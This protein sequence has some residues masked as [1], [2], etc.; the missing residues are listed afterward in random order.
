MSSA[1]ARKPIFELLSLAL[2]TVAQ[3]ASYTLMQFIDRWMLSRLGGDAPTAAANAGMLSFS[4]VA[5]GMGIIMLVNTLV[6]QSFGRQ[7][8]ARCGQYL[9]QGIWL[10]LVLGLIMLPLRFIAPGLFAIFHHPAQQ[11]AMEISYYQIVLLC[12]SIKLSSFALSQFMLGVDRPNPVLFSAVFGVA[13]NA[14][15]AWCVVLGHWGFSKHGIIGAAW[16]QNLGVACELLALVAFALQPSIRK[17]Y[18]VLSPALH[19]DQLFTLVK[20]GLPSGLQFFSDVLAWSIFCNGV[21][22]ILGAPAMRANTFML[23]YMVVSFMPAFGLSAA[24]TALVGRYIGSGQPE[25]SAR[26]GSLGFLGH[27]SLYVFLRRDLHPG[28]RAADAILYE[29]S[30][31]DPHRRN[32]FNLRRDL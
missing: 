13:V 4:L 24:V 11:E 26:R 23:G 15:G 17:K 7:E 1:P 12:A 3:M 18:A 22:G 27:A 25:I 6:S 5:L 29:R 14:L 16:M 9:W 2:P 28:A 32:I 19:L 31:G 8:F 20:I 21:I 10:A 30:A